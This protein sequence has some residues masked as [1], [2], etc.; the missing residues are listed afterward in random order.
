MIVHRHWRLYSDDECSQECHG[1]FYA[2]PP[3]GYAISAS[4]A[5]TVTGTGITCFDGKGR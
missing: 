5:G 3:D 1:Q 2:N 4:L